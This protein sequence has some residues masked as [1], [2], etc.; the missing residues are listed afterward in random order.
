MCKKIFLIIACIMLIASCSKKE[1]SRPQISPPVESK[2]TAEKAGPSE[3]EVQPKAPEKPAESTTPEKPKSDMSLNV[4]GEYS[5]VLISARR[6]ARKTVAHLGIDQAIQ[7]FRAEHDRFP[8]DLN[9]LKGAGYDIPNP[10]SG[11]EYDYNPKTGE[12]NVYFK[13][14]T[15]PGK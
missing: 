10:P 9:E 6:L 2:G 15:A 5:G 3:K 12:F 4:V 14:K 13:A 1:T 7:A 11:M 8:N